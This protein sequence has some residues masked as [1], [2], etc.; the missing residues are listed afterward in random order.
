VFYFGEKF[1][2]DEK[3]GD[4][5]RGLE[6]WKILFLMWGGGEAAGHT[7]SVDHLLSLL[8]LFLGGKETN[9]MVP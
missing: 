9:I 6:F 2:W 4:P 8:F 7:H 1:K 5:P 3:G